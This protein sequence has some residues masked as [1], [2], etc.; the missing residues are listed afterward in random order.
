METLTDIKIWN[1]KSLINQID[2]SYPVIHAPNNFSID[3][4]CEI[5]MNEEWWKKGRDL[6]SE[7]F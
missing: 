6:E 1:Q 4:K 2:S 7:A 5:K 3:L